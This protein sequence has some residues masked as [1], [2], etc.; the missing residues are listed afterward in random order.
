VALRTEQRLAE[1]FAE[2]RNNLEGQWARGYEINTEDLRVALR[3][4]RS[5]FQTLVE[6]PWSAVRNR[7]RDAGPDRVRQ[8]AP[9]R[10]PPLLPRHWCGDGTAVVR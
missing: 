9:K 6:R 3:E 1:S 8:L 2:A 10:R 5:F 7:H 4:Y